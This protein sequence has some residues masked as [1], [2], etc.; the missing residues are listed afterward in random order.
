LDRNQ[1]VEQIRGVIEMLERV[2]QRPGMYLGSLRPYKKGLAHFLVGFRCGCY[3]CGLSFD[4]S[5]YIEVASLRGWSF[6]SEWP[7]V[8][9]M[10]KQ[11][12]LSDATIQ[13]EVLTIEVAVWRQ[14][15][16][17]LVAAEG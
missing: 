17:R 13:D 5:L 10:K 14:L 2:Q 4:V 6:K 11:A 16:E 7:D 1:R 8:R 12:K 3:A 9:L 15:Q